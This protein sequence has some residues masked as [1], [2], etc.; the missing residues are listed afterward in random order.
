MTTR[1]FTGVALAVAAVVA[2]V[3]AWS[4]VIQS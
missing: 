4:I 1:L 3:A 2:S